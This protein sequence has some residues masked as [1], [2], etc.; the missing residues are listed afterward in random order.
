MKHIARILLFL[1]LA[2]LWSC[3]KNEVITTLPAPVIVVDNGGVY[4]TKQGQTI[5]LAPRVEVV[6]GAVWSWFCEGVKVG[7]QT[8]YDFCKEEAGTYYILLRVE[9]T[10]GHDEQEFRIEVLPVTPPKISFCAKNRVIEAE[11]GIAT[12]IEPQVSGG[13]GAD[14]EW[15]LDDE[16]LSQEPIC[17]LTPLHEGDHTLRLTVEN[18]DGRADES[19]TLRVV[20][21]LTGSVI[22]PAPTGF[23]AATVKYVPQGR[24]IVLAPTIEGFKQPSFAWQV[25]GVSISQEPMLLLTPSDGK[26][27]RV[28][29]TVTDSDGYALTTEIDVI[30]SPEESYYYRKATAESSNG[31]SRVFEYSPAPG[32][33][34]GEDKSGFSGAERSQEDAVAY[35]ESRL[36]ERKYISLGGWGGRLVVGFDHSIDNDEGADLSISGNMLTTSSEAGIVWVMQDNN[37]NGEPDDEWYELRGSEWGGESHTTRYAVTYFRPAA[38][39]MPV[40]WRDNRGGEGKVPY[41]AIHKQASYYPSWVEQDHF[42]LYGSQ[43][44]QNSTYTNGIVSHNPYQWGYADNLGSDSEGAAADDNDASACLLDIANA[45]AADGTA[46]ALQHIDFVMIQ[47]AINGADS[48]TGELSTEVLGIEEI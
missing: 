1:A 25:D 31:W 23:G 4:A 33:F 30:C 43:L 35:A 13:E 46:V 2:L 16:L 18:E 10:S 3:N 32:Q 12:R 11:V 27:S 9:N 29:V 40:C 47:T 17:E 5:T 21:H 19:V 44:A 37:G 22:F 34:I 45:V 6:D 28:E 8:T 20:K 7:G 38:E 39:N 14:Y 24:S 36:S 42:T 26:P 41:M 15:W 48:I